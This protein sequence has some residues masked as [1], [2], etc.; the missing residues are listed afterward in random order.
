MEMQHTRDLRIQKLDRVIGL[1]ARSA[2]WSRKALEHETGYSYATVANILQTLLEKKIVCVS[3]TEPSAGGRKPL[4][5]SLN[6]EAAHFLSF[7]IGTARVKWALQDLSGEMLLQGMVTGQDSIPFEDVVGE[8]VTEARDSLPGHG[9]SMQDIDSV[10]VGIPGHYRAS[11]DRIVR[12][13]SERVGSLHL[14]R[15]LRPL[16]ADRVIIE[17]DAHVS[18]RRDIAT[19]L[20]DNGERSAVLYILVSEEGVGSSIVMRNQVHYGAGR[21]AGEIHM[22]PVRAKQTVVTLGDLLDFDKTKAAAEL[23][24][25]QT[26]TVES[27]QELL[28]GDDPA[29]IEIYPAIVEGLAE[30]VYLLDNVL[31]PDYVIVSGIYNVLKERLQA[32]ILR[33]L[34]KRAEPHLMDNLEL[35]FAPP[36]R[37]LVLKGLAHIQAEQWRRDRTGTL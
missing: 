21:H 13:S 30:A 27:F 31:D 16:G 2:G 22:L 3:S 36:H 20:P 4:L 17:T 14:E 32:D 23:Q 19:L 29:V 37:D 28:L 33:E 9:L 34:T 5:Y 26:L 18:A 25:G 7:D 11:D 15:L 6:P 24:I 12:S 10:G 35:V 1:F 8:A